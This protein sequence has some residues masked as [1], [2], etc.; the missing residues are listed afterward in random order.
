M[1]PDLNT[2]RRLEVAVLVVIAAAAGAAEVRVRL[3]PHPNA[4]A[5]A[6][7]ASIV[8]RLS[9]SQEVARAADR[10]PGGQYRLSLPGE[11][12]WEISAEAEG[13]W[14]EAVLWNPGEPGELSLRI[15]RRA[16]LAGTFEY[17]GEAPPRIEGRIYS[18]AAEGPAAVADPAGAGM[19]T[20]CEF[21]FPDWRC[22][23]PADV[24]FDLRLDVTGFSTVHY[25][26]VTAAKGVPRPLEPRRLYRG[27]SLAGWVQDPEG[28]PLP[29]A[30]LTLYPLEAETSRTDAPRRAARLGTAVTNARGFFQFSGLE[31]G[32]YRIVSEAKGL[33]PA[34]IGEVRVRDG[35]SVVWPRAIVHAPLAVL[36]VTL[37]PATYSDGSPW[38]LE[39]IEKSPL[40]LA[41]E[42]PKSGR[43]TPAGRWSA[44]K[45]RADLHQLTVLAPDGSE[46]E[47]LEVD[48]SAGGAQ[49]V[50][51]NVRTIVRQGA[52]HFGDE[53]LEADVTFSDRSGKVV[54]ASSDE[55]GRFRAVFPTAGTWSPEVRYPRE[56]GGTVELPDIEIDPSGTDA[57]DLRVA[58][59]RITGQVFSPA[60]VAE[61]A[62]VR[63]LREGRPIAQFTTPSSGKFDFIGIS[64]GA[65]AIEA[66][67]EDGATAKPLPIELDEDE[68][69]DIRLALAPLR[70]LYGI[71]VTPHGAPASG[72]VIQVLKDGG[73]SWTRVVTDVAGRFDY[74]VP[75]GI[76]ELAFV[77]ITYSYPSALVRVPAEARGA[78]TVALKND[79]G[80]LRIRNAPIPYVRSIDVAAPLR[81]FLFPEP[82][83]R[84]HGGAHLEPGSYV[85]CPNRGVDATCRSVVLT[86]GA[87]IEIDFKPVKTGKKQESAAL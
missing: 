32:G 13:C 17:D 82:F 31:S 87:D 72:A 79:G 84:F 48:L 64:A 47:R 71:V 33:S 51:V 86:P 40:H 25:W 59:G 27:A 39:L 12:A 43:G 2:L 78:I 38:R 85:V 45:L 62:A 30:K 70:R 5:C 29:A 11:E 68:V 18:L 74:P 54:R 15:Y 57:I 24:P 26:S 21:E 14:S 60:G 65:Y 23:A 50:T 20:A 34:R 4:E 56:S 41:A 80:V 6:A 22:A 61:R 66:E 53:P 83:G 63:V 55:D 58:G 19:R 42:P 67:G 52:I 75:A 77:V 28:L 69:T 36:E 9:E 16:T 1:L 3:V 73:R 44:A 35:E 7:A 76:G 49:F 37:H 46:L 8:A 81:A 10:D